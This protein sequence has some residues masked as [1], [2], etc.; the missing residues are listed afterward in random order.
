MFFSGRDVFESA[1]LIS[2]SA[3]LDFHSQHSAL[4]TDRDLNSC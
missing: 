1:V 3:I 2:P 4:E